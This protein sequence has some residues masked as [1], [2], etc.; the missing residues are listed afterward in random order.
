[1]VTTETQNPEVQEISFFQSLL[2]DQFQP[3]KMD[4][5]I[6]GAIVTI[7]DDDVL[8]D[9][10]YKSEGVIPVEEFRDMEK[11]KEGERICVLLEGLEDEKGRVLLSKLKADKILN[12]EK[13]VAACEEG[14]IV[15][16]KIYKR[17]KGGLMV[18]VG[19]DAFLPASQIALRN[20]K[21]LN[22]FIGQ[23][24]EF[25]VLKINY[26]RKNIVL[27]RRLLLEEEKKRDKSKFFE[28]VNVGDVVD[29][30][31][32]NIT[33]FGAF[34]DLDGIDGLLHITDMAWKRIKH[35][36]EMVSIGDHLNVKI[37]E[38]DREKERVSLGLKQKTENPWEKIEERYPVGTKISGR[39]VNIMPYGAFVELE[40][41]VEGLMHISELSW[42]K[43][44]HHP[45]EMLSIG[46]TVTAVVLSVE[47]EA[48][49][50]S[51]GLKQLDEN[52]WETVTER[53]KPGQRV[54]GKVRNLTNYGVFLQLEEG[55]DGLIHVSD[56]SWTK[57]VNNPS[58]VV[59]KGVELEAVV[60]FVDPE[61]RKISLGVKQLSEDPWTEIQSSY[62]VGEVVSGTVSKIT[63]FGAFI[64]IG[65]DVEGLVHISHIDTDH[66]EDIASVLKEGEDVKVKI[67][68]IDP[69]EKKISLSI[70]EAY[71]VGRNLTS[72]KGLGTL[73]DSSEIS[74]LDSLKLDDVP[75]GD[76]A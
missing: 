41:G 15:S 27:S 16:G 14:K 35:P 71:M 24:Y 49:K 62:P 23:T 7:S 52:P 45:S 70:K 75:A 73:S 1:M 20:P 60:L 33:D 54:Q 9:I 48:R 39:V 76:D 8:I 43:R 65:D 37:L 26:E 57:K 64:K 66:T 67:L 11:Y 68:S 30:I 42:V 5:V 17:V 25:K 10:N 50:I 55:I 2:D 18:D 28:R 36:S 4:T 22:D 3:L 59:E 13:T 32:K 38:F 47:K 51:L 74:V 19:M 46:D 69:D 61:N 58:E 21:N 63:K 44:I 53:Y 40:D 72:K 6:S 31:V 29:G 12:W 56:L 34:I